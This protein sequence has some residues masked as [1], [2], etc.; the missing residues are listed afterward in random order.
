MSNIFHIHT[1]RCGHA[2]NVS[3]EAYIK[4]AIELGASTIIFTDHAP[5]P[6]NLFGNRMR[7]EQLPEYID[8]L[9][10]LKQQYKN[11]ID[12]RIGLEMEYLPGFQSYYEELAADSRLDLLM[13]GQHFYEIKQGEYSF[14]FPDMKEME[15]AGCLNAIM[16]GIETGL[17]QV[18][19][20]P[21]RSFRYKGNWDLDCERI[22][23]EFFACVLNYPV[24]LE[25]NISS[26]NTK[27]YY[28]NEFWQ[29]MP[30]RIDTIVGL[31]AHSIYEMEE[32][33]QLQL[34]MQQPEIVSGYW[35]YEGK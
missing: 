35:K 33:Y 34:S 20:H 21:D 6:G 23:K 25:R 26:M 12:V 7:Y 30:E 32:R 17:F 27:N 19:A 10:K 29:L 13:L 1:Y 3:D 22:S 5:F 11:I 31:D 9:Q 15:Y 24:M 18:V 2:E 14:S 8:T 28:R 16:Q 4:K